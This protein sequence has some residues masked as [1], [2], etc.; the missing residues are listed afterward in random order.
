MNNLCLA[1]SLTPTNAQMLN[2]WLNMK[3]K[4]LIRELEIKECHTITN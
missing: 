3:I 1:N 2:R 4:I